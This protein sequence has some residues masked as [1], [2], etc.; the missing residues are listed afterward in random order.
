MVSGKEKE[1]LKKEK[2]KRERRQK[3]FCI[4]QNKTGTTSLT[5]ALNKHGYRTAKQSV[6]ERLS[7]GWL[8]GDVEPIIKLVNRY[9][10]FQDRP[11][12]MNDLYKHLDEHFPDSKFILSIRDDAD[13]WYNSLIRFHSKVFGNGSKPTVE[14]LKR[15]GYIHTGW[16]YD[17]LKGLYKTS[18]DDIYNKDNLI[19]YYNTY[20]ANVIDYFKDRPDD[21]LIIN[22]KDKDSYQK[23]CKF[24]GKIP[25]LETFPHLNKTK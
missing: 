24:I 25:K 16:I 12:Y 20:N 7:K 15:S 10:A 13:E 11:F 23:F 21:L 6:G 1:K 14:Q 2:R 3:I 4:G 8:E 17:M 22:L 18:D 19:N 9:K 5:K